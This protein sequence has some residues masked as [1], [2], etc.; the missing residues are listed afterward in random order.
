MNRITSKPLRNHLHCRYGGIKNRGKRAVYITIVPLT[1]KLITGKPPAQPGDSRRFD[2]YG[3]RRNVLVPTTRRGD[4]M[5][6][7]L[8]T[9]EPG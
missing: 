3:S 7:S 5:G 2:R 1:S 8:P 6:T 9:G 4:G